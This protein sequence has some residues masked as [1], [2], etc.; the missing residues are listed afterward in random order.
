ML[1]L[2]VFSYPESRVMSGSGVGLVDMPSG[3]A[4]KVNRKLSTPMEK[5]LVMAVD[6]IGADIVV[7]KDRE[8][9]DDEEGE[10]AERSLCGICLRKRGM[11]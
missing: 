3:D 11:G 10:D 2:V 5:Q 6:T 7:K 9:G 1:R 4:A 8:G